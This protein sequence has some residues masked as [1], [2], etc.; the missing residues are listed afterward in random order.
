MEI[1]SAE[2]TDLVSLVN[3]FTDAIAVQGKEHYSAEQVRAWADRATDSSFKD[4][5]LSPTTF[6]A[7]D[8]TD[9]GG[10]AGTP[11]G[12]SGYDMDG[13]ITSLYVRPDCAGQGVG[14]ALLTY[15]LDHAR[16]NGVTKFHVE[17]STMAIPL[18]E[19]FGF[20]KSGF[21]EITVGA[22]K[23]RRQLMTLKDGATP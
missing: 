11:M 9:D 14:K 1:R 23:F 22:A 12:F 7:V 2:E 6:V 5:V 19:K 15:V 8:D 18:F 16:E 10:P 17:A 3:L 4:Y 21:D 20:E 13:H